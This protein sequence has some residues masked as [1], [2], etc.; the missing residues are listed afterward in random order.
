M[1]ETDTLDSVIA[2]IFSQKQ[3]NGNWHPIVYY[4]K[5]IADAK[6]NYPIHDKEML[7]IIFSFQHWRAQ[8][9]GAPE[10]I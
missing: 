2:S 10:P 8:L 1:L 7:A 9:E 3:L 5:T 4:L 6:L